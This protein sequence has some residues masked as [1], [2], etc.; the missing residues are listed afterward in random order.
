MNPMNI[1]SSNLTGNPVFYTKETW[2]SPY[3]S[4]AAG[5]TVREEPDTLELFLAGREQQLKEG[6]RRRQNW[7]P[8]ENAGFPV[9]LQ[10]AVLLYDRRPLWLEA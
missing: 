5:W 4:M 2:D 9:I 1:L 6:E 3:E 7:M 10:H 8:L